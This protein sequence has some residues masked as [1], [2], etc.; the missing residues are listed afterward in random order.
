MKS[1]KP[2]VKICGISRLSDAKLAI[3][4]GAD[5]IGF[6]A[7]HKSPR[8]QT[9]KQIEQISQK[10]PSKFPKVLVTVNLDHKTL[11]KYVEAGIN[12]VQ[13]HG[14]E[15]VNYAKQI[16]IPIWRAIRLHSISQIK[17]NFPCQMFIIDSV[18]PNS[19]VYGGTG[20][21][22]DWKLAKQFIEYQATPTLIAGGI[23]TTNFQSALQNTK[24]YGVDISSSLEDSPA[25]KN[26]QKIRQFFS[27]F[28][29]SI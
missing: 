29:D 15:D 14:E 26:H 4:L 13:L 28:V 24:A 1:T 19:K 3:K 6:I 9:P 11:D 10:L 21:K 16:K 23:G 27:E 17:E 7:H 12:I 8:F 5:A 2:F 22:A 25:I 18:S 20:K